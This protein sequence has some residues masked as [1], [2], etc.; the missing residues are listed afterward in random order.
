V[1]VRN[2]ILGTLTIP[3]YGGVEISQ[4]YTYLAGRTRLRLSDG[5]GILRQA[6]GGKLSTDITGR[7]TIPSGLLALDYSATMT[8]A[9]AV[10]MVK[11]GTTTIVIPAGRRS[12]TDHTPW[13]R[14]RVGDAWVVTPN[15]IATNTM[16]ITAVS[17]AS[18]YQAVWYP[19]FTAIVDPPTETTDRN[20]A[21]VEW[22]IHAEEA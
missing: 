22:S 15:S 18:E 14:A 11:S 3:Y 2:I 5:A 6:W 1:T 20:N 9:C 19:S 16:T 13:A 21:D 12:D 7:G 8:V 10:P 17:G 4:S